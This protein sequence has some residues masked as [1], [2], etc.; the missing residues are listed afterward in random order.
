MVGDVLSLY[1][2][3][4]LYPSIVGQTLAEVVFS[5]GPNYFWTSVRSPHVGTVK[6]C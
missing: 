2:L 6:E 5:Y 1:K 4:N 3:N